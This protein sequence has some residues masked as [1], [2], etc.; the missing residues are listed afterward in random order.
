MH[1]I[2]LA[3]IPTLMFSLSSCGGNGETKVAP[4]KSAAELAYI[5]ENSPI[6]KARLDAAIA[7]LFLSLIHI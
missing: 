7:P 6:A 3:M 4:Q 1:K 2:K 5:S